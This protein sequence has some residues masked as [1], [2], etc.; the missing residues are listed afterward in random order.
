MICTDD[1]VRNRPWAYTA[2]AKPVDDAAL[3]VAVIVEK[4]NV[5]VV[6]TERS[7]M[8]K[9]WGRLELICAPVEPVTEMVLD[10]SDPD[11]FTRTERTVDDKM[12]TLDCNRPKK[13]VIST[14][15]PMSRPTANDWPVEEKVDD[16]M[17]TLHVVHDTRNLT[18]ASLN[19]VNVDVVTVMATP[20]SAAAL[21]TVMPRMLELRERV[22]V[23]LDDVMLNEDAV[24]P[25]VVV[26]V[27]V[28]NWFRPQA[29]DAMLL[30]RTDR[31][32]RTRMKKRSPCPPNVI[33]HN[34]PYHLKVR[35]QQQ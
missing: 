9:K 17:L 1:E 20:D 19:P 27:V 10:V 31:R 16:T 11:M 21:V 5:V 14:P 22:K 3:T 33:L 24:R 15:V 34:N 29:A 6:A 26:V 8:A 13:D 32:L 28:M 25:Q 18:A 7:D 23:T 2:E 30:L 35:F 4:I 12:T